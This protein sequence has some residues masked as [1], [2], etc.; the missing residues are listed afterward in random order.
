TWRAF[1][2]ARL[3]RH[4]SVTA[5]PRRRLRTTWRGLGCGT[6]AASSGRCTIISPTTRRANRYLRRAPIPNCAC[7]DT[8]IGYGVTHA[9]LT[10]LFRTLTYPFP[11]PEGLLLPE[12]CSLVKSL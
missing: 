10:A 6:T 2:S 9:D 7:R 8:G 1:R 12:F 4:A 11:Y 3:R 5:S